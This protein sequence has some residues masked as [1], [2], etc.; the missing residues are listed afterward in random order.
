MRLRNR[1]GA[2][3]PFAGFLAAVFVVVIFPPAIVHAV[4]APITPQVTHFAI[5]ERFCKPPTYRHSTCFAMRRVE[6][7][8]DTTGA[9]PY[10]LAAGANPSAA[11]D[12]PTATIGPA[13]GLTPGDL[14]TAYGFNSTGAGVTVA[15]V[16]AY[17]DPNI[18]ADLQVFDKQYGLAACTKANGCLSVVNQ[19]GGSTLPANDT[20]GWSGE[21]SLDVQAM[22][23]VCQSCKIILIE[24]TSDSNSDLAAAVNEAVK[25]GA[26]VISNSYGG[27]E[28][29]STAAEI[30]AYNHPG[31]V[32]T[33]SAGDD[34]YYDFDDLGVPSPTNQPDAPASFNTV[35]AV[36]GTSL[37]LGQ[38]ATRQ[39]ETVWNDNGT[40]AFFES[41]IGLPLGATGGGC[42]TL[43]KAQAWQD[44]LSNW[45]GT[46]CG[47]HRLVSDIAAD[48]DYLTG[49]DIYD[50]Y[51][52]GGVCSVGWQTVGGTSLSSPIIAGLFALA[53]GAHGIAYPALTLYG[54]LGSANLYN[55][56]TGGNGYCG[57]EGAAACGDPNTF[58]VGI[59]DCDYPAAGTTPSV[60]DVACDAGVGYNGPTGVGTP[61]G[62]G[63]FA[64]TGP[65]AAISGPKSVVKLTSNT[66]TA[67]GTDPFPG[68]TIK[69]Y[70]WNWG[71]G[72]APTVT[73]TGSAVHAY[74][75]GLVTETIT[76]TVADNYQVTGKQTY[77]V[78]VTN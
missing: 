47:A 33:A 62:L 3:G 49:F 17:N 48:A 35:V 44:K 5:G 72:T 69:S 39:S 25:L 42:S 2:V 53:G 60:G 15:I 52:C 26:K 45:A 6:V 36:G 56:T 7:A 54:H 63:A 30:A 67:T 8:E 1:A 41:F 10:E 59:L 51:D 29:G 64:L 46:A 4:D 73:T 65:T 68:G 61:N 43:I 57:G 76:L 11:T 71:D 78:T 18:E 12:G 55:V 31:V 74:A 37:Y 38:S 23:S 28:A 13:G 32:I 20:T 16:D 21:E 40:E 14:M 58:G 9:L 27:P 70:S 22:H 75:K 66:W 77:S 19:T 50:T 34:G 24:A